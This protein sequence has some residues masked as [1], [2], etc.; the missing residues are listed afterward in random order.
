MLHTQCQHLSLA[1]FAYKLPTSAYKL[2]TKKVI[3]LHILHDSIY[4]ILYKI[5]YIVSLSVCCI[6]CSNVADVARQNVSRV[7]EHLYIIIRTIGQTYSSK[8]FL[9]KWY[10]LFTFK[11]KIINKK[12]AN[13]DKINAVNVVVHV[14]LIYEECIEG[15][16][17]NPY[18]FSY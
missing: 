1:E 11:L 3:G 14:G 12:W 6:F 8:L 17:L 18:N 10:G 9:S 4:M 15:I 5:L 13:S 2:P 7:C 16:L